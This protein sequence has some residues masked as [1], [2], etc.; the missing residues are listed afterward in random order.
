MEILPEYSNWSHRPRNFFSSPSFL[1]G[2]SFAIRNS[3]LAVAL[4]TYHAAEASTHSKSFRVLANGAGSTCRCNT[5]QSIDPAILPEAKRS[6]GP[7][8]IR[9]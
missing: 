7:P 6:V 3:F 9:T 5:L 8:S 4:E 1:G 2:T